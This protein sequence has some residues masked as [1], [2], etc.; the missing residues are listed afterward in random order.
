MEFERQRESSE[1]V[2]KGN[3]IQ[4]DSCVTVSYDQEGITRTFLIYSFKRKEMSRRECVGGGG[5]EKDGTDEA[6]STE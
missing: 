3:A 1:N 5:R 6:L 4:A 2:I